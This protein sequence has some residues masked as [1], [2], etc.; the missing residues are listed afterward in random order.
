MSEIPFSEQATQAENLPQSEISKVKEIDWLEILKNK[1]QDEYGK[2]S[3]SDA[4]EMLFL[5][6]EK[7]SERAEVNKLFNQVIDL[8]L[9]SCQRLV[10]N[11]QK[12]LEEDPTDDS[13]KNNLEKRLK[14]LASIKE[15]N[16]WSKSEV[17]EE[18][19]KANAW[20]D[21]QFR[22]FKEA[23]NEVNSEAAE[24]DKITRSL[25]EDYLPDSVELP[26][27]TDRFVPLLSQEYSMLAKKVAPLSPVDFANRTAAFAEPPMV[28]QT[29]NAAVKIQ[30]TQLRFM[31]QN[32]SDF[33]LMNYPLASSAKETLF[34]EGLHMVTDQT[35][36][37]L[38]SVTLD[39]GV[40]LAVEQRGFRTFLFLTSGDREGKMHEWATGE[41]TKK[42][43]EQAIDEGAVVLMQHL[44]SVDKNLSDI[45][46]MFSVRDVLNKRRDQFSKAY[47]EAAL[48]TCD[49]VEKVGLEPL[50]RSYIN[51][52]LD[53]WKKAIAETLS[54]DDLEEYIH[55]M[56]DIQSQM[57][58][59]D[60]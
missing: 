2:P 47:M 30:L 4:S 51:S 8:E 16:Q 3:F 48:L 43:A 19:A 11:N 15:L 45:D 9:N 53:A 24:A 56:K 57:S 44:G 6:H 33:E 20:L 46:K 25:F 14:R 27:L 34:H 35:T 59:V 18:R 13:A 55:Q 60:T 21:E 36:R 50:L 26:N 49:M 29:R 41:V 7:G 54:E 23:I 32:P 38:G 58:L 12:K 42:Q 39:N 1:L 37:K 22:R 5:A 10:E 31:A 52:N 17:P 28:D 40:I